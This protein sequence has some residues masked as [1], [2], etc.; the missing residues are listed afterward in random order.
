MMTHSRSSPFRKKGN[1][2]KHHQ[3][4]P[5]SGLYAQVVLGEVHLL[6]ASIGDIRTVDLSVGVTRECEKTD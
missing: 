1:P 4:Q 2:W 5:Y 6:V 3:R